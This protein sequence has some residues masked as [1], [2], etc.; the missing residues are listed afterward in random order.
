MAAGPKST[1]HAGPGPDFDLTRYFADLKLPAMPDFEALTAANRRNL[2]ALT[3]ANKVAVEGAQAVARRHMEI[4]QQSLAEM[5]EAMRGLATPEAPQAKAARQAAFAKAAY[6][7][8]VANLKELSDLIQR[9]NAEAVGL[10][11]QR[12]TAALDEV[13]ALAEKAK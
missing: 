6:E 1:P 10:L 9:S 13:K 2:E 7:R 8:A 5:T 3:A 11:N 4:M 12:F